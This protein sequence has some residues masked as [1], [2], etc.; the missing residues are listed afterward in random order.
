MKI[1]LRRILMLSVL[2]CGFLLPAVFGAEQP[3]DTNK[4]VNTTIADSNSGILK[5][6]VD[7]GDA[8]VYYEIAGEGTPV[9]L[10][11]AHSVDCR[12][13]DSQFLEL[14]KHYKVIRYD[15]RG[16]GKTDRPVPGEKFS[17]AEDLH[18]LMYFLGIQKAHLVGLSLGADVA[19]DFLALY[20]RQILSLTV[21]SSDIRD[22]FVSQPV[23]AQNIESYKKQWLEFLLSIC[24]PHKNEIKPQLQQMINNWSG[25][26][27]L[28]IEPSQ[29]LDPPAAVQLKNE[30]PDVPVLVLIGKRD[31][32]RGIRSSK[33]LLKILPTARKKYLK[34]AGHFSNMETPQAFNKVL[35]DFLS[36]VK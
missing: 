1:N 14:A 33:T 17:H 16:Y 18:K 8:Y 11:H 21:A 22:A 7:I 12:M 29:K 2:F 27:V 9:I 36:S 24:G 6:Y 19:V 3:Q 30:K 13:W 23:Q 4:N 35:I 32:D 31:S 26:Q 34:N 25:W 10:I 5:K 20:P 15:L 28:H